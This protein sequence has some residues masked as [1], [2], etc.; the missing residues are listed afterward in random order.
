[1][2]ATA[3]AVQVHVYR[4]I[5]ESSVSELHAMAQFLKIMHDSAWRVE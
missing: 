4:L 5:I 2:V 3:A 1:M